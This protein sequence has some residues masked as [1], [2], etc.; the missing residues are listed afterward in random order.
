[1]NTIPRFASHWTKC[2]SLAATMSLLALPAASRADAD[3]AMDAC[4]KAFVDANVPKEHPVRLE[5]ARTVDGPL[6]GNEG[7]YRI[8]LTATGAKSGKKIASGSCTVDRRG[9]IIA[10]TG[11]PVT[12]QLAS[13]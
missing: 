8:L 12:P 7:P 10:M 1:M 2:L 5:K 9:E 6:A 3:A 11:R 4:L 13:R